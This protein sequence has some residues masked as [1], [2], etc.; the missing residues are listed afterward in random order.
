MY[1]LQRVLGLA[2][3]LI[4]MV[5][6]NTRLLLISRRPRH[7]LGLT[8]QHTHTEARYRLTLSVLC[9]S[10][11]SLL[12]YPVA[13][14]T[15]TATNVHCYT[16]NVYS[17]DRFTVYCVKFVTFLLQIINLGVNFFFYFAFSSRFRQLLKLRIRCC[18]SGGGGGGGGQAKVAGSGGGGKLSS[19]NTVHS[20]MTNTSS[21]GPTSSRGM[22]D[23]RNAQDGRHEP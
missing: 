14:V 10:L 20:S 3:P 22:T 12:S 7:N 5:L 16:G 9:I 8:E 15:E 2:L 4:L 17:C 1:Y 11:S 6:C 18:R 23:D 21:Q 13:I 19:V